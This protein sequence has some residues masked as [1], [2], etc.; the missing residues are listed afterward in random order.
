MNRSPALVQQYS[1]AK[2]FENFFKLIYHCSIKSPK[3]EIN[4]FE[5]YEINFTPIPPFV[6]IIGYPRYVVKW[7]IIFRNSHL[8]LFLTLLFVFIKDSTCSRS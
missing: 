1:S 8:I 7:N 2:I 3:L 4:Q 6:N 5:F